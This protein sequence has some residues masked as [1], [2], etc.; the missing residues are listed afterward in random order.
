MTSRWEKLSFLNAIN[1]PLSVS[2]VVP[3]D[4]SERPKRYFQVKKAKDAIYNTYHRKQECWTA[5][6]TASLKTMT[7]ATGLTAA[8]YEAAP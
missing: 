8:D 2:S 6:E 4:K 7:D 5:S 3:A 1:H